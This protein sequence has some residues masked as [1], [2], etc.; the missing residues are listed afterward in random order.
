M[1]R[2]DLA[3][4]TASDLE[5]ARDSVRGQ[6]LWL[7]DSEAQKT[8][9]FHLRDLALA[10][11]A[12]EIRPLRAEIR[13]ACTNARAGYEATASYLP[14]IWQLPKVDAAAIERLPA[15]AA[16]LLFAE[17]SCTQAASARHDE[18]TDAALESAVDMVSRFWTLLVAAYEELERVA[19]F[20]GLEHAVPPLST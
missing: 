14:E 20:L 6:S 4:K 16:A 9:Y 5:E 13:Q 7:P 3:T 18:V 8:S 11:D 15:L 12:T 10:L 1:T 19:R 2:A 17:R